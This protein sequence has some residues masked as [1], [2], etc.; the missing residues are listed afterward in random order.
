[1]S[2]NKKRN[3]VGKV[4]GV[5]FS[6]ILIVATLYL[7]FNLVKLNILPSK[8]L[9]LITIIF[10]L[11]DLIFVLLLC[12]MT[13]GFGSKLLCI[14]FSV[15]ISLVSCLGGYYLSETGGSFSNI[16]NVTKEVLL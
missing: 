16:T 7:L 1:M 14:I 5:I 10:V 4:F 11:L 2:K 15:I 6:I 13:K 3:K 12:F 9:F 8:L